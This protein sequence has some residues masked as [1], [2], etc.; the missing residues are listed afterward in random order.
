MEEALRELES[1]YKSFDYWMNHYAC[2][3]MTTQ[4]QAYKE[5]KIK[6]KQAL[7]TNTNK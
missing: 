2:T 3:Q 4:K 1:S 5:F 6:F 7:N